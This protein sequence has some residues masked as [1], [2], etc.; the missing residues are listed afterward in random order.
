MLLDGLAT[1]NAVAVLAEDAELSPEEAAILGVSRP[2][3]RRRMDAGLLP[4]RR[5]GAHRRV[6]LSDVLALR[7]KEEEQRRALAELAADTEDIERTHGL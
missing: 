3:V 2:L 5:V 1:S 7:V 6:R 4:F